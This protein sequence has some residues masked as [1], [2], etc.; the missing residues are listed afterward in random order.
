MARS[1]L[2]VEHMSEV[3][4]FRI[5][6]EDGSSAEVEVPMTFHDVPQEVAAR[7]VFVPEAERVSHLLAWRLDVPLEAAQRLVDEL[8][9]GEG[10]VVA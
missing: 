3:L 10:V 4:R 5:E 6:Y 2:G 8:L 9:R 1:D 7:L